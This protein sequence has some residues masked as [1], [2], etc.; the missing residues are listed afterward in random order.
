MKS[1]LPHNYGK[2]GY[3]NI[4]GK[5]FYVNKKD[6]FIPLAI[7]FG[8]VCG[9]AAL[10]K[11]FQLVS[12]S[13]V[14]APVVNAQELVTS[15]VRDEDRTDSLALV[16][17]SSAK[18]KLAKV[19]AYSCGGLKT[20]AEIDM[21]CPSIRKYPKGRTNS[22]TTPRPY[23]TVACDREYMGQ[24][25]ILDGIGEVTCEDTG[26]AIKGEGRFDLYLPTVQEARDFGVQR[27]LY[28][29]D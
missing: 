16:A 15:S 1:R 18:Y 12:P 20:E 3:K 10:P 6:R 25:F 24:K 27:L 23:I 7:M 21:N 13:I 14:F 22:G 28:R 5:R 17:T 9:T 19:T 26:G 4:F 29:E 11:A 2:N 8:L